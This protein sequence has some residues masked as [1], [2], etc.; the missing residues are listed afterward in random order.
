MGKNALL[1]FF[2]TRTHSSKK[3]FELVIHIDH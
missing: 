3:E 2:D 1:G